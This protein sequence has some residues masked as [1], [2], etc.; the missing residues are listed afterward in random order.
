MSVLNFVIKIDTR[1]QK[2]LEFS[3]DFKTKNICLKFADYGCEVEDSDGTWIDIPIRFE[4]KGLG[5]LFGTMGKGYE[6]F[7][8]EMEKAKKA[9]CKLFLLVEGSLKRV[10][11]GYT[12]SMISGDSM[13]KKLAMLEIRYGLHVHYFNDRAEMTR[14]IEEI[15]E[16]VVRNHP[17]PL[18]H[19][20]ASVTISTPVKALS[21]K[22]TSSFSS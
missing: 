21:R 5:D 12:Y 15:Y 20:P 14:F 22:T 18:H 3:R 6:R 7:K 16:A 10:N 11:K 17:N 2:E 4:R 19:Y 9:N 8:I 13:L 1:E